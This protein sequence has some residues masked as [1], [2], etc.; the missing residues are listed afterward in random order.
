MT[1]ITN[2]ENLRHYKS[3][4]FYFRADTSFCFQALTWLGKLR[5]CLQT[6]NELHNDVLRYR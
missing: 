3:R 5:I 2:T 1:T 4:F 6:S